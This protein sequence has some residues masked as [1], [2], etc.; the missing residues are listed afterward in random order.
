[1]EDL[2]DKEMMTVIG[3][4]FVQSKH[5]NYYSHDGVKQEH[6][7]HRMIQMGSREEIFARRCSCSYIVNAQG[8]DCVGVRL[9]M[10]KESA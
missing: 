10:T 8:D 2:P 3:R 7:A 1:M 5:C 4:F 9:S 6:L